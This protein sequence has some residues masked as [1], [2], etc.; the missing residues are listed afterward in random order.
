MSIIITPGETKLIE[1]F[2]D[3]N[4]NVIIEN[5]LVGDIHIRKD[6][7]T[8]YILERKAGSDLDASIKD[9][10]YKEQKSRLFETGI[11]RKNIIYIIEKL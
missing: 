5:L 2:K 10:R 4:Y 6:D 9:G 7:K 1:A 11:P 8:V 3:Q